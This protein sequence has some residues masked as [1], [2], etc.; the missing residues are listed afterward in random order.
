MS[1]PVLLHLHREDQ[2]RPSLPRTKGSGWSWARQSQPPRSMKSESFAE[3]SSDRR[4][5]IAITQPVVGN[6]APLVTFRVPGSLSTPCPP[7][8]AGHR[9]PRKGRT[10]CGAL[11]DVRPACHDFWLTYNPFVRLNAKSGAT[12][13]AS[14]YETGV[15]SAIEEIRKEEGPKTLRLL[16]FRA[17]PGRHRASACPR[18][19]AAPRGSGR[20]RRHPPRSQRAWPRGSPTKSQRSPAGRTGRANPT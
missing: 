1:T 18:V 17:R 19:R 12:S 8:P 3:I 7:G 10:T 20:T 16:G 13:S 15:R 4:R 14:V 5:A 6:H 2:S 9:R 11:A